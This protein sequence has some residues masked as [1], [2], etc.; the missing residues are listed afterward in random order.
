MYKLLL[1]TLSTAEFSLVPKIVNIHQLKVIEKQTFYNFMYVS[2]SY[3]FQL[4][5]KKNILL[6]ISILQTSNFDNFDET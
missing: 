5:P 6:G 3:S 1:C 4:K 2:L